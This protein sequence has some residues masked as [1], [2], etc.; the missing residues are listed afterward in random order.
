MDRDELAKAQKMVSDLRVI[1]EQVI[2]Q[3]EKMAR[4]LIDIK[5]AE[6]AEEKTLI[7]SLTL[8]ELMNDLGGTNGR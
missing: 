1:V 7:A 8:T 4:A 3:N 2:N 6:T 5:N